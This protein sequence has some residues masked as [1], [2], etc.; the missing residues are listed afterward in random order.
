MNENIKNILSKELIDEIETIENKNKDNLNANY[1]LYVHIFPKELNGYDYDKYYVGITNNIKRR[2]RCNGL[3]YKSKKYN[4]S[5]FWNAIQKYGWDNIQ[6]EVI[7]NN[8]SKLEAEKLEEKLIT[9][10]KSNYHDFGYNRT[11]GGEGGNKSGGVNI[12]QYNLQGDFI[13]IF[14]SLKEACYD[15]KCESYNIIASMKKENGQSGGYMW[16]RVINGEYQLKIKPYINP[17]PKTKSVI[18]YDENW[19]ELRKFNSIKEASEYLNISASNISSIC[20]KKS[21]LKAAGY[22]WRFG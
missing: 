8:L 5:C 10:L 1:N 19:N 15:L 18:Q 14:S 17:K 20:N 2:W 6:H 13:K 4:N 21:N 16:R 7:S 12:A 22:H 3:E 11:K 9:F